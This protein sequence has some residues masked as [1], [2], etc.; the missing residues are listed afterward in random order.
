MLKCINMDK[1]AY[2]MMKVNALNYIKESYD[3]EEKAYE[4]EKLMY[5]EIDNFRKNRNC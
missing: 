2:K 4:F 3:Y 5:K 1:E